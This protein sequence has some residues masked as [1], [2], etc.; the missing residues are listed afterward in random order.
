MSAHEHTIEEEW[1][2]YLV[3]VTKMLDTLAEC[4]KEIMKQD[5]FS[6]TESVNLFTIGTLWHDLQ[7]Q[8]KVEQGY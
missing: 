8:K 2:E 6:L 5:A 3:N 1:R 4:R 7:K